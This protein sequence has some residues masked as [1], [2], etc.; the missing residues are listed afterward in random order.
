M[1]LCS[2]LLCPTCS[3]CWSQEDFAKLSNIA[4]MTNPDFMPTHMSQNYKDVHGRKDKGLLSFQRLPGLFY[5]PSSNH[6]SFRCHAWL[7]LIMCHVLCL[8]PVSFLHA[9]CWLV[10]IRYCSTQIWPVPQIRE[11]SFL[12]HIECFLLPL[13]VLVMILNEY[14]CLCVHCVCT[15][16]YMGL[17]EVNLGCCVLGAIHLVFWDRSLLGLDSLTRGTQGF[18]CFCLCSSGALGL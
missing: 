11:G 4:P 6:S 13:E 14:V 17:A 2:F 16:M 15:C 12:S 5:S 8:G 10:L 1:R 18:S 7:R 9:A 3:S